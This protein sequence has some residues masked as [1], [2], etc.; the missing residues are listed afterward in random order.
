MA[1]HSAAGTA[2]NSRV[3]DNDN[4]VESASDPF[5]ITVESYTD[6]Y[7]VLRLRGEFDLTSR[8]SLEHALADVVA[9]CS[10]VVVDL[11][12]VTF[13]YSGAA[14]VLLGAAGSANLG[15]RLSAPSRSAA[16]VLAAL[17]T[18]LTP[19]PHASACTAA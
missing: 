8:A 6:C 9:R 17:D 2:I 19:E 18:E 12:G 1:V 16:V 3:T 4:Y 14:A 10:S 5:R 7:S 15:V 13:L 11:S